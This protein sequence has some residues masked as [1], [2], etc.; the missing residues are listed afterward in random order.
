MEKEY[1][2]YGIVDSKSQEYLYIGKS[3]NYEKRISEHK[4]N[5]RNKKGTYN[6]NP[7]LYDYLFYN[8]HYYRKIHACKDK[9]QLDVFEKE[10]IKTHSP[11]FNKYCTPGYKLSEEHKGAISEFH[12][13]KSKSEEH[14]RKIGEG[15]RGKVVSEEHKRKI[16][17]SNKGNQYTKGHSLT[18]EHK[19]KI[20]ESH[21]GK[22]LSE[23]HKRKISESNKGKSREDNAGNRNWAWRHD[24]DTQ[25]LLEMREQGMSYKK[26][27]KATGL[28][29]NAVRNRIKKYGKSI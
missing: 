26:I 29:Y 20:S 8:K 2:V 5:T 15:N 1:H 19:R 9:E 3:G 10:Y 28:S 18:E 22:L 7:E 6:K 23:E 25:D 12:K 24:V 14:K 11:R 21:K 16:S 17:E 27:S 4:C 13:G